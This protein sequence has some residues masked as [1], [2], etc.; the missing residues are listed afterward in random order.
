MKR[1]REAHDKSIHMKRLQKSI[2]SEG[3]GV[4]PR[5]FPKLNLRHGYSFII[6][7][8]G[9]QNIALSKASAGLQAGAVKMTGRSDG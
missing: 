5:S 8:L 3:E 9:V 4:P 1:L 7:G 6:R 2:E